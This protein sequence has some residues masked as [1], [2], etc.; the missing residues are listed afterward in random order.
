MTTPAQAAQPSPERIFETLSAFQETAALRAA[1]ELD[2]FTAIGAGATTAAAVAQRCGA[3]ERG[4]RF[5]CDYLTV[6][7]FLTKSG[8]RYG[9]TTDSAV[10]LDRRSPACMASV[11]QFLGSATMTERFGHLAEAVRKGGTTLG[12]DAGLAPDHP[13]WVDFA[14]GMAPMMIFPA[15]QIAGLLWA[16]AGKPWKVLDIAAGHG[17]FGITL[18]KHNPQAEIVAVDWAAVLAV[19]KANAQAAGVA[20]RY[21]AL[22]GSAFEVEFGNGYDVVLLTNF[23]HHFDAATNEKL[24]RKVN[25]A[26]KPGARA[27]TLEFV[28][29]EDRVTPA[30]AAKFSLTMLAGTDHGDAYT[31]PEYEKMFRNAGFSSST[32]HPIPPAPEQVILSVK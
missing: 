5:L 23:L 31:F 18:A 32:I 20:G 10:F 2:V 29:N 16:G 15:E 8:D 26:L 24:L 14:K 30:V 12:D 1:I 22:P 28:P 7:E 9:L 25:A 13:M 19:A 21:R 17:M 27:V 6:L 4:T 3:S 11:S